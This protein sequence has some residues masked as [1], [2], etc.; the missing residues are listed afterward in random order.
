M[1]AYATP[2]RLPE[3]AERRAA[4]AEES[5]LTEQTDE[6]GGEA[7][8]RTDARISA[9]AWQTT[10][11]LAHDGDDVRERTTTTSSVRRRR[12]PERF[13]ALFSRRPRN[14]RTR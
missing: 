2:D 3:A 1:A 4:W 5:A 10:F 11:F 12:F 13:F 9:R 8:R 7:V 6:D 14:E